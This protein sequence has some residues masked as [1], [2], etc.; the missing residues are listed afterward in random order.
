MKE[1]AVADQDFELAARL[2]DKKDKWRSRMLSTELA[3]AWPDYSDE[4]VGGLI[5]AWI[6]R[7]ADG[8]RAP[9]KSW[10]NLAE[11]DIELSALGDDFWARYSERI[12][13]KAS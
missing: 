5:G 13:G 3:S 7:I 1:I 12:S 4:K 2:R 9:N 6:D 8:I 10:A 11:N